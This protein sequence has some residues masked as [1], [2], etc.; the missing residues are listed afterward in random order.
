MRE[1]NVL[2]YGG[3]GHDH[4]PGAAVAITAAA[5]TGPAAGRHGEP[6]ERLRAGGES[7]AIGGY[8]RAINVT[9]FAFRLINKSTSPAGGTR[10]VFYHRRT[11]WGFTPLVL[12]SLLSS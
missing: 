9:L 11:Y 3:E 1:K 2:G 12:F 8:I 7:G 6:G 4:T 10:P 5:I